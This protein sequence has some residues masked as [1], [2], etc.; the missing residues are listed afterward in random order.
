MFETAVYPT[1]FEKCGSVREVD[2]LL[3]CD[4]IV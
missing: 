2:H 4:I 3:P 1:N